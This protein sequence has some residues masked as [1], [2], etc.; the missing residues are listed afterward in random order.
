[1][2]NDNKRSDLVAGSS[3]APTQSATSLAAT[4]TGDPPVLP[5]LTSLEFGQ[6][7][8]SLDT[9]V[10]AFCFYFVEILVVIHEL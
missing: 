6:S 1:M 7:K 3:S 8:F 2:Q 10:S 9:A 4:R 5:P